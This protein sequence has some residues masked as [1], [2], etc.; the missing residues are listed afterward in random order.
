MRVTFPKTGNI[1]AFTALLNPGI[2]Y[3]VLHIKE[4]HRYLNCENPICSRTFVEFR[5]KKYCNMQCAKE[6]QKLKK[7]IV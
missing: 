3:K 1:P 6:H 4:E 5:D 2:G 7:E